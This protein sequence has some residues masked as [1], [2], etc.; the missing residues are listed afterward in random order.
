MYL[1]D[2]GFKKN[3]QE[4]IAEGWEI[5]QSTV[6]R[7]RKLVMNI[8]F[9]SK[10]RKLTFEHIDVRNFANGLVKDIAPKIITQGIRFTKKI[11]SDLG[12][13][14]MD[15]AHVYTAL[16]NII[17]NAMD[18]C[19]RSQT[20]KQPE[21]GFRVEVNHSS[22]LFEISDN[23]VGMDNETLAR[24]F[25]PFFS[26]KGSEGTGL[27]LFVANTIVQQHGGAVD[28]TSASGRGTVFRVKLP[29]QQAR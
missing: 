3:E 13:M 27:G 10:E 29:R 28:V 12:T 17:E 14:T 5:V 15:S 21:I 1:V 26:S 16:I 24:I 4:Q 19:Q 7:I 23:G 9:Y 2:S 18:A 22:V 8:L 11:G 25:T 20:Q 6:D